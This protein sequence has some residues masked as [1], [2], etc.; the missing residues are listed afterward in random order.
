MAPPSPA[1]GLS[2]ATA[3]RGPA[4]P[5]RARQILRD[6]AGGFDDQARRQR[7][8]NI[9]QRY[10]DG[11][12][13]DGEALAPQ[14]HDRKRR[15]GSRLGGE[16]GEELRVAGMLKA[17]L[18]EHVFRDRARGHAACPPGAGQSNSRL[19]RLD[20]S[21]R[22]RL[23]GMARDRMNGIVEL[24]DREATSESGDGV[25]DL[26]HSNYGCSETAFRSQALEMLDVSDDGEGGE[27]VFFTI[28]PRPQ[29]DLR[30]DP[31]G[32]AESDGD[33]W[34]LGAHWNRPPPASPSFP[35]ACVTP[36]S[37][38]VRNSSRIMIERLSAFAPKAPSLGVAV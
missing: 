14:H 8:W 31:G 28:M 25:L 21:R 20:D 9:R 30:P 18:V 10:M 5:K 26:L 33:R 17:G 12:R 13:H 37:P 36:T 22:I 3:S 2:P 34:V 38:R 1:C 19:D 24:Q 35:I 29:R 6:D 4:M 11:N 23:V 32:I 7:L 16:R 27:P 15:L